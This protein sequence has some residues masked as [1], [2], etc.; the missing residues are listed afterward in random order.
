MTN[1][2]LTS[3]GNEMKSQIQILINSRN[4]LAKELRA[5]E[6]E[7]MDFSEESSYFNELWHDANDCRN[8]IITINSQI[9]SL[10]GE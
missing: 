9:Q 2:T 6:F 8:K 1:E 10:E 5:T 7:M 3:K 4:D